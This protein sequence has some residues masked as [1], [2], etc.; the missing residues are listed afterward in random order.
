MAAAAPSGTCPMK[1]SGSCPSGVCPLTRIGQAMIAVSMGGLTVYV[2]RQMFDVMKLR[3]ELFESEEFKAKPE[4]QVMSEKF[5]ATFG[6][7]MEG[8]YPDM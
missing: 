2:A 5:K 1:G 6:Q 8:G 4:F 7:D 3:K